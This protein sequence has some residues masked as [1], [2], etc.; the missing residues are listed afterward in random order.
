M[1]AGFLSAYVRS[2]AW[3]ELGGGLVAAHELNA[4]TGYK[5]LSCI[6]G[7]SI[8]SPSTVCWIV[9]VHL[10]FSLCSV[11]IPPGKVS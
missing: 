6:G 10:I 7:R 4:V 11:H 9:L 3:P 8:D 5:T 2:G 1:V